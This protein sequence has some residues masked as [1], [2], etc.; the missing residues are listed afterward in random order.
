MKYY[1][2]KKF[3]VFS[4]FFGWAVIFFFSYQ[5]NMYWLLW[6]SNSTPAPLSCMQHISCFMISFS[7][8]LA[9]PHQFGCII[10]SYMLVF[11]IF[12]EV[13]QQY[14]FYGFPQQGCS[15]LQYQK[16]HVVTLNQGIATSSTNY[17]HLSMSWQQW[18][19]ADQSRHR[20]YPVACHLQLQ[21]VMVII[22]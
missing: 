1:N 4:F 9:Q 18:D 3:D 17:P 20:P 13:Y 8:L 19:S 16:Q 7:F 22:S 10:P 12:N 21:K 2:L 11:S 15:P 14:Q 6:N 5:Q